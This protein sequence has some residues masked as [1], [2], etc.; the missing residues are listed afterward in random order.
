M[1]R[2]QVSVIAITCVIVC[3]FAVL[4]IF[5]LKG[6]EN[7]TVSFT[8]AQKTNKLVSDL[9]AANKSVASGKWSEGK[10]T[11]DGETYVYNKYIKNYLIMGVDKSGKVEK[12]SD[13]V[14]GGQ[15]DA[16][17]LLVTDDLNKC[18]SVI[19][20]NRNTMT[21][22]RLCDANGNYY[23]TFNAQICL[24]H[25][26]GDGMRGSCEKTVEAVSTLFYDV[27]I[28][29]YIAMNM[30]GMKILNHAAGGVTVTV[31]EDLDNDGM[32]VHLKKGETVRLT[33]DEA[34]VYLRYR[35]TADFGSASM[36]L[37]RE[38]QYSLALYDALKQ[39]V[40]GDADAAV[41]IYDSLS[42]YI[43]SNLIFSEIAE[44]LINYGFDES[45]M[46][47]VD[48]ELK[49]GEKFEEFYVDKESLYGIII[50]TMYTR[51]EGK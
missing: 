25:G 28:A 20:I 32:G 49:Q 33:D 47:D 45:R 27:P 2:K 37:E 19:P 39:K 30:D 1:S 13:Y 24:Q 3:V 38:E 44:R 10:I 50:Q 48:G 5:V 34:Y 14:S 11:Y 36:R 26:Y 40:N 42:D 4:A 8:R 16:M 35:D 17:F 6:I 51:S 31:L 23:G 22:I 21:P 12:A 18:V 7:G 29:G 46:F 43:V 41:D 9:T 15:S